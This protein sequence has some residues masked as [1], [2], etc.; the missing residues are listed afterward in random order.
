MEQLF[1]CNAYHQLLTIRN[2]NNRTANRN[3]RPKKDLKILFCYETLLSLWQ[4]GYV[5]SL[6]KAL[7][8][9]P[10]LY[11]NELI[12]RDSSKIFLSHNL[13]TLCLQRIYHWLLTGKAQLYYYQSTI[14]KMFWKISELVTIC[15]V[16]CMLVLFISQTNW[17]AK[18]WKHALEGVF[19]KRRLH[20]QLLYRYNFIRQFKNTILKKNSFF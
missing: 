9:R 13:A 17:D 16:K 6:I 5:R 3:I 1:T 12:H 15:S 11:W 19:F 20:L 7:S 4:K 10:K 14:W 2:R 8:L 18:F